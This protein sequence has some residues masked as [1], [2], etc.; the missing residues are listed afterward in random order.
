MTVARHACRALAP[1]MNGRNKPCFAC[2]APTL[3][4]TRKTQQAQKTQQRHSSHHMPAAIV[5]REEY[6]NDTLK[7]P[8]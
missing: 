1:C 5:I 2:S 6:K 8:P 3:Y 4:K 7:R